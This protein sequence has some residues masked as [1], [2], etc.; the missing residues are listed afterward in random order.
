MQLNSNFGTQA[1]TGKRAL[2]AAPKVIHVYSDSRAVVDFDS[3]SE[4]E[5]RR[6]R[7]RIRLPLD[8]ESVGPSAPDQRA[9][10]ALDETSFRD[11]SGAGVADVTSGR[12]PT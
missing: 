9:V 10:N 6:Q 11:A 4:R 12:S 5:G 3:A 1:E 8:A 2:S 7:G